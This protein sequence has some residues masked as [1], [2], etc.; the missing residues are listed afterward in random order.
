MSIAKYNI[1]HPSRDVN[2]VGEV[3]GT[4]GSTVRYV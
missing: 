2:G 1:K 4:I 3:T